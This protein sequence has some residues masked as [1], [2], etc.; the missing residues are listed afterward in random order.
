MA[1]SNIELN[2]IPYVCTFSFWS[3]DGGTYKLVCGKMMTGFEVQ[4]WHGDTVVSSKKIDWNIPPD[5]QAAKELIE[6]FLKSK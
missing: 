3:K 6:I 1:Q 5:Y 4:I 2:D